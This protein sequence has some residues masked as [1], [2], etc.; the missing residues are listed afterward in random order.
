MCE[1]SSSEDEIVTELLR[2]SMQAPGMFCRVTT[3]FECHAL[4]TVP[5]SMVRTNGHFCCSLYLFLFGGDLVVY[6][7]GS[8]RGDVL[9]KAYP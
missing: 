1:L 3:M 2:E 8:E 4:F 7:M 5:G 6:L 9:M